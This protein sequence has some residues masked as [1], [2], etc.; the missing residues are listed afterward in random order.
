M[1]YHKDPVCGMSVPETT[2]LKLTLNEQTYYF[3]SRHCLDKFANEHKVKSHAIESDVSCP[4][5]SVSHAPYFYQNKNFIVGASLVF[6]TILSYLLPILEPFRYALFLYVKKIWWAV[7]LGLFIGGIID[8]LIPREY[9]SKILARRRKRTIF[10]SVLLGFLM[11]ACSHG[12]LAISI[13]LYKKGAPSS[14]VVSFLL[15]SPWANLTMTFMLIG[16]FGI[17]GFYIILAAI[18]IALVTGLIFQQYLEKNNLVEKNPYTSEISDEN[19]S[20]I[21]DV[22]HRIR[23]YSPT[24][25]NLFNDIKGIIN[26]SISLS[27]MVLWWILIGIGISSLVGAYVP[28]HFFHK[29]LSATF[30]GLIVTLVIATIIEVCSEGTAPLAFEIYRQTGA[31]GNSFVFLMAGVATDYTELG[32]LWTN[33][34]KKTA[35]WTLA[36][37]LPQ[38]IILGY[39]ANLLR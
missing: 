14:S 4:S 24:F 31:L 5:C 3:C 35:L 16:F 26:G 33:I 19:F 28:P 22:K 36:I 8:H 20:I 2:D 27:D 34:G 23:N 6:L 7:L 21:N 29:Y 38:I 32:L 18:L 17:K 11:S 1:N 12:I 25:S 13:A 39:L 9:I 37:T 10:Y 30:G 15:A